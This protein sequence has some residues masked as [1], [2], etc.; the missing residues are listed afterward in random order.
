[1]SCE[2][3]FYDLE[4]PLENIL[5]VLVEKVYAGKG[6]CVIYV[7]TQEQCAQWNS[8]LWTYTTLSFLPHASSAQNL[9]DD[10]IAMQPIFITN[11][12]ENKNEATVAFNLTASIVKDAASYLRVVE[13][14]ACWQEDSDHEWTASNRRSAYASVCPG[15]S[16]TLLKQQSGEWVRNVLEGG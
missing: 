11:E 1:M 13:F 2:L 15:I 7:D 3:F 8:K 6:R 5:P 9:P 12:W 4:V 10:K 14:F 16:C